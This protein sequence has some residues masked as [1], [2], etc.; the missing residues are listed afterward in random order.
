MPVICPQC[1]KEHL[2]LEEMEQ[3]KGGI[4][5]TIVK[6]PSEEIDK[7]VKKIRKRSMTP[8]EEPE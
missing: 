4:G 5:N 2:T 3:A 7:V 6:I 1:G 8:L